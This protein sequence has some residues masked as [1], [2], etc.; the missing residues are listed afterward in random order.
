MRAKLNNYETGFDSTGGEL[1]PLVLIHG[2]PLDRRVWTQQSCGLADAASVITPDLPGFG[3]SAPRPGAA[4]M[5]GYADAVRDVMDYVGA[6]ASVIGGV[7]MGGYV[8]LA[9]ARRYPQ[10]VRALVLVDTRAGAD[11]DDAKKGRDETAALVRAQGSAALADKM[12]VK[13]LTEETFRENASLKDDLRA[14]LASQPPEGVVAALAAM[15]D[16]PD[17]TPM[18]GKIAVPT[19]VVCGENDA[20][21]P[22]DESKS[23][24]SAIPGAKAA[25]IAGAGHLP[26]YERPN[27][28][29]EVLR[30]FLKGL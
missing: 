12:L 14:M 24:A 2:F 7:S 11:S 25:W 29:N 27:E 5:D 20:V 3:E 17:S 26:N 16:R 23:L 21:I 18:L 28:F 30:S 15:R 10:R 19:L 8:A 4:T 6:G 9:F 13:L 22:P 1:N